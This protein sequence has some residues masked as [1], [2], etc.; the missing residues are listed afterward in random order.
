MSRVLFLFPTT[1]YRAEAFLSAARRMGLEVAVASEEPSSVA[2]LNPAGLV[3]LD[4]GD[5]ERAAA[6]LGAF[7]GRWPVDAIVAVDERTVLLA[8]L[9]SRSLGLSHNPPQAAAAAA[10]KLRM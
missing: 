6:Q 4:F 10:D 3:D 8:S 2:A 1:T 9:L 7:A 5:P